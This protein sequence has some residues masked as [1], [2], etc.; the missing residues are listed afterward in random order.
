MAT[1]TVTVADASG[2]YK[3]SPFAATATVTGTSG[4]AGASLDGVT[5]TVLYYD[6]SS[7][8]GASSMTAPSVPGTYT[9]TATYPATGDYLAS[10]TASATFQII[11]AMPI[12]SVADA[13]GVYNGSPFAAKVTVT[14]ISGVAGSS[15]D[16]VS[17]TLTYYAGNT[18][19]GAP[20]SAAPS[21]A[22]TYTVLANYAGSPDYQQAPP[23]VAFFSIDPDT[24]TV[25]VTASSSSAVYGQSVTFT[26]TVTAP[27]S[28]PLTGTVTFFDGATEIGAAPL[29]TAGTATLTISNLGLGGNSITARYSGDADALGAA[30]GQSATVSVAQGKSDVTL[31]SVPFKHKKKVVS[32]SLNARITPEA[33]GSGVPTGTVIF[34]LLQKSKKAKP[35]VLGTVGLSGGTATLLVKPATVKNKTLEVIYS[36][37]AN[38]QASSVTTKA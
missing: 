21:A 7:A 34:E 10:Q 17:P 26:A 24:A 16:G 9:V 11:K 19:T 31:V 29:G 3:G 15:L 36:G 23:A 20:L 6:G 12:L 30:L 37:D 14:G 38:F 35:K 8:T 5:P 18:A 28:T 1:P 27:G 32:L 33:P 22:G 25:S 4:I 13:G 2:V